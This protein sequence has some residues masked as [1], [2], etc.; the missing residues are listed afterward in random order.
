MFLCNVNIKQKINK[1]IIKENEKINFS[2]LNYRGLHFY[3][4]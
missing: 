2:N 3:K 4:L 1:Q